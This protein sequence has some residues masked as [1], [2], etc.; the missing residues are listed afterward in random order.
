[1]Y[2]PFVK[3]SSRPHTNGVGNKGGQ[4]VFEYYKY[5]KKVIQ[6]FRKFQLYCLFKVT[7]EL[8]MYG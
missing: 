3:C 7:F 2:L 4:L 8:G 5:L 6:L 1:M